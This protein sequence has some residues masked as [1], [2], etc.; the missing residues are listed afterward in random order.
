[1]EGGWKEGELKHKNC[2]SYNHNTLYSHICTSL[3]SPRLELVALSTAVGRENS[4]DS[5]DN[6]LPNS[7]SCIFT[8]QTIH[9]LTHVSEY[10]SDGQNVQLGVDL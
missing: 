7:L 10:P 2:V 1:M 4:H 8:I 3:A 5:S 9:R 6:P